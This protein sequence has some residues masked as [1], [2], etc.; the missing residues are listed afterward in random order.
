MPNA[1]I[2]AIGSEMLTPEKV[3]TNSLFLTRELNNLGIA[4]TGKRVVGDSREEIAEAI[5]QCMARADVVIISGGLGPTEDDLT[6]DGAALALGRQ[7]LLNNEVLE[8]IA[9]RFRKFNRPMTD[10]N[11]RQAYILEGARV[12]A[13]PHGTAPGQAIE[14]DGKLLF[15]L[16]GPPRELQP[17]V[18]DY[19][20]PIWAGFFP[21]RVL[22]TFTFRIA[23]MPESEVDELAA[24]V[25]TRF[26]NPET[27]ILAS[28]GDITL[29]FRATA[30]TE[31]EA[32]RLLAQVADPIREIL[33]GRIYSEDGSS[34]E[35][36]L[37]RH[38]LE[39]GHTMAVAESCT[40]GMLA[41]R[42]ANVP[43]ASR[44]LLGGFLV[45]T[46]AMKQHLAGVDPLLLESHSAVSKEVAM[47]LAAETRDRTGAHYAVSITGYAGPDGGTEA[48]PVGTVYVGIASP[49][50]HFAERLSFPGDR[51]RVR[52]FSA[53]WALDIL[54]VEVLRHPLNP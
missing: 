42:V 47:A 4:V 36:T 39:R 33:G 17:M 20:I 13:N 16:P 1:Q 52:R 5:Q 3:D 26:T 10:R 34:L 14:A 32:A 12:L 23:R 22:R 46:D 8:G 21:P 6:R 25:Y 41:A 2:I 40:A 54:R 38:L 9:A 24:P 50:R 19:C 45:Y 30:E 35:E 43:G 37:V 53:Q 31:V 7:L 18:Q 29:Q 15:L 49:D 48:D 28:A 11:R 44:V 51:D 27:T